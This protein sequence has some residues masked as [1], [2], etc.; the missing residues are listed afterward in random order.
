MHARIWD[1][2]VLNESINGTFLQTRNFL[3]YHPEGRFFDLSF[4]ITDD[5]SNALLA[6]VPGCVVIDG[7]LKI[8]YSHKGSTYGGIIVSRNVFRASYIMEL[9]DL[10]EKT[11]V[12]ENFDKVVFKLT[13]SIFSSAKSDLLEYCFSYNRYQLLSELSTYIDIANYDSD[14]M[15]NFNQMKR[16]TVKKCIKENLKFK[17]LTNEN[18]LSDFYQLLCKN[19][20]KYNA[21]P[22]HTFSEISDFIRNR[23]IYN[24]RLYGVYQGELLVAGTMVFLFPERKAIHTQY[25][26][27]EQELS[28][29]SPMSFLFYNLIIETK[30]LD[31]LYLS[32]GISTEKHGAYL[33]LPLITSKEGFGSSYSLNRTF[34]KELRK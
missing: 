22:V 17:I 12:D 25:L 30:K 3:S 4:V 11:L 31:Y 21:K 1:D 24:V 29:L 18:E 16:R 23:L 13:P 6:V 26:A 10:V 2:F 8:Y 28:K 34:I 14:I 5:K 27:S 15:S 33:N 19:L 9:I 7:G 32:W 20:A